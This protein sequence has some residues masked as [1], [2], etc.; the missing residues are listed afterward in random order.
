MKKTV[1]EETPYAFAFGVE[2]VIL[3]EIGS[4]SYCVEV[5]WPET[6]D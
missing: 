3:A 2:A 1:T 4:G 6:N 5:F